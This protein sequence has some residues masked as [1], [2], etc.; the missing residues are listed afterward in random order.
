MDTSVFL[1]LNVIEIEPKKSE[2]MCVKS[3]HQT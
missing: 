2:H 3:L 1:I